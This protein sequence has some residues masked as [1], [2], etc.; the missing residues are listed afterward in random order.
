MKAP[1]LLTLFYPML[2]SEKFLD[3]G[4]LGVYGVFDLA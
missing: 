4:A 1:T 3:V 2:S